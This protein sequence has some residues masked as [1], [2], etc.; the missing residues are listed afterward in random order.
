M[1]RVERFKILKGIKMNAPLVD[2]VIKKGFISDKESTRTGK[3]N[4][5]IPG[6]IVSNEMYMNVAKDI[7]KNKK[8]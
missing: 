7:Q 4:R 8:K 3:G 1:G 2:V 6:E 5:A